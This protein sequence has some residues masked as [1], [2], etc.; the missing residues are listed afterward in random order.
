MVDDGDLDLVGAVG[1]CDL[2]LGPG[3]VLE[4]I[5]NE[6]DHDA[7]QMVGVDPDGRG[8]VDPDRDLPGGV[9]DLLDD[10]A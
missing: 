5:L 3:G 8:S 2:D 1:N 10:G 9:G 6:I 7:T 4:S